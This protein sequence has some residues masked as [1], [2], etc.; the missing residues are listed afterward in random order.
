MRQSGFMA[1]TALYALEH[2]V[3]RLAEDHAHAKQI[4]DTLRTRSFIKDIFPVETNLIIFELV[5]GS[6]PKT[7]SDR[8]KESGIWL[9]PIS[10]TR[11]RMVTHLDISPQMVGKVCQSIRNL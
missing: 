2:H 5:P 10:S 6:D 8:M 4:A 11:L 7:F 9:L 3:D 1:A